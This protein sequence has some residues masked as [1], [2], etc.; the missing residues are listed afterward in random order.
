MEENFSAP[1]YIKKKEYSSQVAVITQ[2]TLT[3]KA[4]YRFQN[5]DKSPKYI[6][7]NFT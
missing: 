7:T 6:L 5:K 3:F 2:L 4:N 1:T